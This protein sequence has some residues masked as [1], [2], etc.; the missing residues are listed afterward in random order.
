MTMFLAVNTLHFTD[1][2]YNR[3]HPEIKDTESFF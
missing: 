3:S 2:H 1:N